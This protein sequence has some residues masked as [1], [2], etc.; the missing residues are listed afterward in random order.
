MRFAA[1][2]NASDAATKS[3]PGQAQRQTKPRALRPTIVVHVFLL[4]N[5]NNSVNGRGKESGKI[6]T[7]IRT[8]CGLLL[9]AA[10]K[11]RSTRALTSTGA[12]EIVTKGPR[13]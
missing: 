3:T 2:L 13:G 1:D 4:L 10:A 8:G 11:W 5:V 12:E 6:R 7:I 9:T